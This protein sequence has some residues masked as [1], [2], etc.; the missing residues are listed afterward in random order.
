M[1]LSKTMESLY[2]TTMKNL[3][4]FDFYD[5]SNVDDLLKPDDLSVGD[6]AAIFAYEN[7]TVF[8]Q[9][10]FVAKLS[11]NDFRLYFQGDIW[12]LSSL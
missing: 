3:D 6:K 12:V 11:K 7:D 4:N 8:G 1:I 5:S 2:V 10:W 9:F